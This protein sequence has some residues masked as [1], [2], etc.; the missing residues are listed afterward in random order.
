MTHALVT[1]NDTFLLF[2]TSIYMGT[3]WSLV[4]FS[5]P[6]APSLTVDTYYQQFVPQ[7]QAATKFLTW[8]TILM[9]AAAI[10]MLV[11]EW[12]TRFMWFPVVVLVGLIAATGLTE[13]R[14]FPL[15]KLMASHIRD[16][17][18]LHST[19]QRWMRLNRVRVALWTVEWLAAASYFAVKRP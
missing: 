5:F 4:F 8:L 18:V 9:T 15:N 14:L 11:D 16:E 7:V 2:A 19:L 17:S 3:G 10:V 12:G 1:I 6:I 13:V